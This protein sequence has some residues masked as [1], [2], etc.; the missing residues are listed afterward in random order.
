MRRVDDD[1]AAGQ[2]LAD[3]IVCVTFQIEGHALWQKCAEALTGRTVEIETN[4]VIRQ[5]FRAIPPRDLTPYDRTHG[6]I[7]VSN[8]RTALTGS[9]DSSAG[10]HRSSKMVR[11]AILPGHDPD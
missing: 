1:A 6:A 2:S 5:A 10:R 11:R 9:L 8:W 3:I 4:R 7:R